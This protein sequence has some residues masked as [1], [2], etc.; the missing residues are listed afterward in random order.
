M[1]GCFFEGR[2]YTKRVARPNAFLLAVIHA[3][4]TIGDPW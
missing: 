1:N 2:P 4:P 3:A